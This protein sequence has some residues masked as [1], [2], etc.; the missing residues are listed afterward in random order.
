MA[1]PNGASYKDILDNLH[2]G[3]Y[4]VDV[5][6][7]ITY[8]NKGAERITGYGAKD[9]VGTACPHGVLRHVDTS[10]Q[11]LCDN[12]C[13]LQA[14]LESARP[15]QAEVYL[16]H[17]EGHRVPVRVRTAPMHDG[18]GE[19]LGAIETFHDSSQSL[20]VLERLSELER[21][22]LLDPLTE[23][24]NRRYIEEHLE[25]CFA[26]NRRYGWHFGVLFLDIDNFKVVNDR[27]GHAAGDEVLKTVSRT[28]AGN[29]RSFDM[30]GRWGGEEFLG[31]CPNVDSYH[32]RAMAERQR[33]LVEQSTAS[34][35][36]QTLSVTVSVGGTLPR[37]A[38]T[39]Q[40]LVRRVDR[41]M[42]QSKRDGRNRVSF[43]L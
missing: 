15:L 3:V 13:P 18:D 41:L 26:L 12:G 22:A 25:D 39:V 5:H 34:F 16:H 32:L 33:M 42:Y 2:D 1:M 19:V 14:A 40:D 31:V 11:I 38:E 35:G 37:T 24:P 10:G 20:A 4:V 8:W 28:L 23:L 7:T 43:G 9:A 27:Y 30:V 17:K 36:G 29:L 21:T 6:R